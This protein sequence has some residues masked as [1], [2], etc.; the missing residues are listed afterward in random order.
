MEHDNSSLHPAFELG[1]K[2]GGSQSLIVAEPNFL[3]ESEEFGSEL[4]SPTALPPEE[5]DTLRRNSSDE[6]ALD[7]NGLTLR[8]EEEST[9]WQVRDSA[10]IQNLDLNLR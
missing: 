9:A 1:G 10:E 6:T 3:E 2:D 7:S 8:G 5:S 4:P